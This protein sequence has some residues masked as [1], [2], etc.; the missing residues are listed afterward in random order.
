V[1]RTNCFSR[2]GATDVRLTLACSRS[3]AFL[4][5]PGFKPLLWPFG[6]DTA[7]CTAPEDHCMG[8]DRKTGARHTHHGYGV[9]NI[10]CNWKVGSGAAGYGGGLHANHPTRTERRSFMGTKS[11][12]NLHHLMHGEMIHDTS[13]LQARSL[14]VISTHKRAVF[15]HKCNIKSITIDTIELAC[16]KLILLIYFTTPL[17]MWLSA[18]VPHLCNLE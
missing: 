8:R 15:F 17:N 11:R 10:G 4:Q 14:T 7:V 3:T 1:F 5:P 12:L 18:E 13:A 16:S 2:V 9:F 6:K